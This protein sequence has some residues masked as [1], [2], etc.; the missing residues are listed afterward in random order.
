MHNL[1]STNR[2]SKLQKLIKKEKKLQKLY[3]TYYNLLIVQDL[4][5][6][7]CQILSITCLKEF[8]KGNENME[9]M[10]KKNARPVELN[11]SI[12][13]AFLNTQILKMI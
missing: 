5:Q 4:W 7:C 2:K 9:M 11:I 3:L 10:I 12:E 1:C 6:A 13:T 8:I